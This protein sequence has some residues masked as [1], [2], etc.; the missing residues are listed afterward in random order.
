MNLQAFTLFYLTFFFFFETFYREWTKRKS[1]ITALKEMHSN[2]VSQGTG[3]SP[4]LY[5]AVCT[6]PGTFVML[7]SKYKLIWSM[8]K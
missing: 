3:K 4:C 1:V 6:L 5:P 8:N 7:I 2:L